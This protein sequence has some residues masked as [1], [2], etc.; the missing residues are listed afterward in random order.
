[1][2][3]SR[4]GSGDTPAVE[5]QNWGETFPP[6]RTGRSAI[7]PSNEVWVMRWHPVDRSAEMDIFGP[8]GIK[9]GSV[10]IPADSRIL[11]FGT[12]G[13]TGE[14]AYFVRTDEVGLQ[15]LSRHRVIRD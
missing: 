5:D 1:M 2:Q 6:F 7:T 11:G 8:D 12:G 15:W 13:G 14:F 9:K 10:E 3:M 4:G